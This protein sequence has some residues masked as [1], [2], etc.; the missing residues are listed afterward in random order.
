MSTNLNAIEFLNELVGKP[1]LYVLKS[2][3]TE[4]YDFGFGRLVEKANRFGKR[5]T[6]GS[7]ILHTLCRIKIIE[8]GRKNKIDIYYEDASCE[9]VYSG[10]QRLI[11]LPIKRVALSDKNDLW[12]DFG[13]YWMVVVTFENGEES[14]RYFTSETERCHLVASDSWLEFN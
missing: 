13:D 8:R 6:I 9:I 12:L 7:Y 14:W 4:L 3:D 2:P 10:F 1:L 5:K 11:G